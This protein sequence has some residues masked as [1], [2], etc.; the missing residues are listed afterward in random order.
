MQFNYESRRI[1]GIFGDS[2]R[3]AARVLATQTVWRRA[4]D[5]NPRYRFEWRKSRRVRD[6]Q[7]VHLFS[8]NGWPGGITPLWQT[9]AVS[10]LNK[11][12]WLAILRL[13]LVIRRAF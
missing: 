9:G 5:S 13:K 8:G 2:G 4:G 12:E 1:A 3:Y 6:L 10:N 11:G 7:G